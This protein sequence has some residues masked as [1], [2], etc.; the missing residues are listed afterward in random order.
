[1]KAS[2][3]ASRGFTIIE[4]AIAVVIIGILVTLASF[5]FIA[6]QKQSR[7]GQRESDTSVIAEALEKYY[8]ENGEYPSCEALRTSPQAVLP[9]LDPEALIM[10]LSDGTNSIVCA[11]ID[12]QTGDVIAFVGDGSTDCQTG[13]SC[14]SWTIK[15]RKESNGEVVVINSRRTTDIATTNGITLLGSATGITSVSLSWNQAANSTSYQI[16]RST[17]SDFSSGN[18]IT[19]HTGTSASIGS[20]GYNTQ[21]YFRIRPSSGAGAQGNWSNIVPIRTDA[22]GTPTIGS[23]TVSGTSTTVNW[24]TANYA[25]NYRI[26]CSFDAVTWTACDRTTTSTTDTISS[27]DQGRQYHYRVRG[28]NGPHSGPWS[29]SAQSVIAITSAP[30]ITDISVRPVY[31]NTSSQPLRNIANGRCLDATGTADGAATVIYQ[32]HGGPNQNWTLNS[33][34]QIVVSNSGKCLNSPSG[35]G[36]GGGVTIVTCSSSNNQRWTILDNGRI[37]NQGASGG[38]LEIPAGGIA[39]NSQ[40]AVTNPCGNNGTSMRWYL[41]TVRWTWDASPCESWQTVQYQYRQRS[42]ELSYTGSWIGPSTS[43]LGAWQPT[44]VGYVYTTD[45][46]ARCTTSHATG[47][48]GGAASSNYT[49]TTPM[50]TEPAGFHIIRHTSTRMSIRGNVS[51]PSGSSPYSIADQYTYENPY[52]PAPHYGYNTWWETRGYGIDIPWG[53]NGTTIIS[54][55]DRI[56]TA[57]PSGTGFRMKIMVRCVNPSTGRASPNTDWIVSGRVNVP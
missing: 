23:A 39:N 49:L 17:S 1:M 46:Q 7:D 37:Q 13:A 8:E 36:T 31:Q 20:L 4:I 40:G 12:S 44:S 19:S 51:C 18:T 22:I 25:L 3:S 16:Q 34:N 30:S 27:Q 33:S 26:Q 50:S 5:S 38:C 45:A 10:P 35:G 14:L 47:P 56:S 32:C 48:W 28:Q 52:N 54:T 9:N 24:N 29:S 53:Y 11:D 2:S 55:Y 42:A 15:Y 43:N 57:I 6:V 41:N 21:Y